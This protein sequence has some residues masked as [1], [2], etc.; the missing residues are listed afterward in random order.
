MPYQGKFDISLEIFW[1]YRM[2]SF[3]R[4]RSSTR[5][6]VMMFWYPLLD[7]SRSSKFLEV[8]AAS[9]VDVCGAPG[10]QNAFST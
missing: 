4:S 3:V 6:M 8:P 1:K 5:S 9:S 10:S 2:L 7:T